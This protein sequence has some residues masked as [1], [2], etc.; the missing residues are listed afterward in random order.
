MTDKVISIALLDDEVL[1]RKSMLFLLSGED[2]LKVVFDGNN[3]EELLSYLDQSDSIHPDI[4]L[5]D[6]RMPVMNGIQTCKVLAERYPDIKV[7]ALSSMDSRFFMEAMVE[8]GASAYLVKSA[9]P[10]KVLET[11][12]TVYQQGL[13]FDRERVSI[14]VSRKTSD[15]L[16]S[17]REVEVL[18]FICAQKSTKEIAEALF[19]SER[20][21]EGH[22]KKLLDKT[23]SKNVVGLILWGLRNHIL[24]FE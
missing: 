17:E 18:R 22:R 21:V 14:V 2:D 10:P 9:E 5:T 7:V 4:L 6:V 1:F 23:Q 3:G 16:L 12:R 15:S 19:I 20:T 13:Y 8:Y 11:I 24:S